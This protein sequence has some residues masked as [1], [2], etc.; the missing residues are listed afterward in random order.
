MAR[1]RRSQ[2]STGDL[3]RAWLELVDT[4]G[5]FLA[6]PVL[7]R[8]WPQ[9]IPQLGAAQKAALTAAK[10]GF[11]AAWDSW[12]KSAVD[13]ALERYCT[14]RDEWIATVRDDVFGWGDKWAPTD[15]T[16][17]RAAVTSPDGRVTVTPTG[18]LRHGDQIGLLVWVIDPSPSLREA[19]LD[20]WAESPIDRMELM[21]R[22]ADLPLGLVTDGRWW[23]L[24]SAPPN[25]LAASGIIDSQTWVEEPEVRD[26][27]VQLMSLRHLVGGKAE[28]RIPQLFKD[29][30][31]AAEEITEALG[32][33]VRQ[34]VELVVA[35]F[36]E[37]A[38]DSAARGEADPLPDDGDAIYEAVVTVLMRVVFLLFAEERGLLP[39]GQLFALGYGLSDQLD[40]LQARAQE[41]GESSLD[42]THL[43]WHRLLATS[44]ALYAGATFEDMRLP[45][46]GGSLFDPERFTFLTA[47]T[48]RGTLALTVSTLR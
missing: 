40:E 27:F 14:A 5:P 33:Q 42:A 13:D 44:Q 16:V 31:L 21:L 6:V 28:E 23:G 15:T 19:P 38:A 8:V 9:G 47:T 41:E 48:E 26:A 3:H 29:S 4:E 34:A 2:K 12:D 45:A 18:V 22:E 36:D 30:V 39:S 7:T 32:V 10:P 43:T 25:T 46:Y 20:G 37:A 17:T 24:V 11:D 35:A 1:R